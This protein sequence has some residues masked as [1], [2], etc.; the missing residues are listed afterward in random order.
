MK[1]FDISHFGFELA[2]KDGTSA[3]TIVELMMGEKTE[4]AEGVELEKLE[5]QVSGKP[6][7]YLFVVQNGSEKTAV[8]ASVLRAGG[9]S[10]AQIDKMYNV[11]YGASVAKGST[12]SAVNE[13][14]AAFLG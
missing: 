7:R 11:G 10:Q 1:A 14:I 4:G 9:L 12:R 2:K 8:S 5:C 13:K 6:V 3:G